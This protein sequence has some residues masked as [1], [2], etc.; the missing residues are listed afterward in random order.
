MDRCGQPN[1]KSE[2]PFARTRGGSLI[3]SSIRSRSGTRWLLQSSSGHRPRCSAQSKSIAPWR[4]WPSGGEF[5][6]SSRPNFQNH[7]CDFGRS[8][9]IRSS[10]GKRGLG[11]HMRVVIFGNSGACERS[12]TNFVESGLF[13]G[14]PPPTPVYLGL[15]SH[16]CALPSPSTGRA[17][18]EGQGRARA[19]REGRRPRGWNSR[20]W[21]P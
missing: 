2:P 18:A 21:S 10:A 9:L 6:N 11:S 7:F 16:Q 5:C 17:E 15:L 19:V 13:G 8:G 3:I 12:H 20:P 4:R 1:A 14:T